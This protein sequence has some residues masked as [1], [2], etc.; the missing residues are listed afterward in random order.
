MCEFL[1]K[2]LD[3]DWS[4]P[5]KQWTEVFHPNSIAFRN[6]PGSQYRIEVMEVSIYF[7]DE[8]SGIHICVE[9]KLPDTI[10]RRIVEE[11]LNNLQQLTGQQGEII[12]L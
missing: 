3:T 5:Y 1:I 10:I 11:V 2:C 12:E 9:G 7:A 8:Y 4:L 6:L